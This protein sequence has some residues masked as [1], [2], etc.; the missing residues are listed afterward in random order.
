MLLRDVLL[1]VVS[2]HGAR[3]QTCTSYCST[4][5]GNGDPHINFAN[6]GKADF[7]GSHRDRYAFVSSPGYQFAPYFQEV[8]FMYKSAVG[9]RQLVHG[10]FMTQATWRVRTAAGRELA[11]KADAMAP[12]EAHVATL[13]GAHASVA[14]ATAL[15][16]SEETT[17]MPW[18]EA[19]YD[20]VRVSTRQLTVSVQTAAWTV[21]VTTK[22]IYGLVPPLLNNTHIHGRWEENQ[23]RLDILIQGA[24]PQADAHGV[25]GQSFRDATRRDGALDSYDIESAPNK[26]NSDGY[27]PAMTTSAQAEGAIDGVHTDYK[28]EDV[29]ATAFA[30]SRFDLKAG[31]RPLGQS[32]RTASTSEWDGV[33]GSESLKR[34]Q[35]PREVG[36]EQMTAVSHGR[37]LQSCTCPTTSFKMIGY[38][39][40]HF[41]N[42]PNNCGAAYVSFWDT[43]CQ[44]A[45][46]PGGTS[47]WNFNSAGHYQIFNDPGGARVFDTIEWYYAWCGGLRGCSV[48]VD[49]A[50]SATTLDNTDSNWN[51]VADTGTLQASTCQ[52]HTMTSVSLS[53][54]YVSAGKP[55]YNWWRLRFR[56]NTAGHGPLVGWMRIVEPS[57]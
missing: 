23:H 54:S 7:R 29:R 39:G 25:I 42:Y 4:A 40:S 14:A 3:G 9:L 30:Y 5:G 50:N 57:A 20:D 44:S 47:G 26:A 17:L 41:E 8:D 56:S 12:G 52:A 11:I 51:A 31:P 27:L 1:L 32:N 49:G 33:A 15:L 53:A 38:S 19:T 2:L 18:E 37:D 24:F 10:T 46:S 28:L 34:A 43:E 13:R 36:S 16:G 22:P 35:P 6:G 21:E 55:A 48:Y 45:S